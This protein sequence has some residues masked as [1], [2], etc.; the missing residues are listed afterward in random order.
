MYNLHMEETTLKFEIAD[1]Y[2]LI[3]PEA[4]GPAELDRLPSF[5]EEL[6]VQKKQDVVISLAKVDTVFSSHLTAFVQVYRLLKSFN[7]RFIIV[8]ISPAV[9]NVLQMTQLD[10]LLPLFLTLPDFRESL[11]IKNQSV[12]E[13]VDFH[14][15]ID[16]LD[17]DLC[18]V[19]CSGY[20]SFGQQ[21]RNLQRD[22]ADRTHILLDIK[23]VGYMDTRVLIMLA[24]LADKVNLEVCG[25]SNVV[26]ELFEQHR[27]VGRIKIRT[28][29][30]L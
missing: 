27:L 13:M 17:G 16:N 10:S 6:L 26:Q 29:D 1:L 24:D 4:L 19:S 15:R 11:A 14:Y 28:E 7:L 18:K 20:M 25:V 21:V 30:A 2:T 23:E 12:P 22:L 5:V 3:A 8:D 9:L